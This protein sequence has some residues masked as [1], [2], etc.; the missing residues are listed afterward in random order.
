[1]NIGPLAVDVRVPFTAYSIV[2]LI[3]EG[4]NIFFSQF[5]LEYPAF[6][7]QDDVKFRIY[8]YYVPG[9]LHYYAIFDNGYNLFA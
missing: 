2:H 1:M 5:Y 4:V 9:S 6:W 8:L 3:C 7:G